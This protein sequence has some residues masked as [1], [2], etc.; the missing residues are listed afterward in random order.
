MNVYE[1]ALNSLDHLVRFS[2]SDVLDMTLHRARRDQ[3]R[4]SM[5]NNQGAM[6]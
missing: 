5:T 4:C 6:K 2:S 3:A 1:A